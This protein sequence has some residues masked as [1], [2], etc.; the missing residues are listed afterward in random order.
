MACAW[1]LLKA[2]LVVFQSLLAWGWLG[3]L[4][5]ARGIF[6]QIC[7]SNWSR[8]CVCFCMTCG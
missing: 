7:A 2:M 4:M 8:C 6:L 1:R 3:L 5:D